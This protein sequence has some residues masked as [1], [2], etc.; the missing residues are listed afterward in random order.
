MD[1][2]MPR[3]T[4]V[5]SAPFHSL[6]G[7]NQSYRGYRLFFDD[8]VLSIHRYPMLS[9]LLDSSILARLQIT[10]TTCLLTSQEIAIFR[11]TP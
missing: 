1:P 5:R 10:Q 7:T 2:I 6:D 9:F 4:T 8:A 3:V 11:R